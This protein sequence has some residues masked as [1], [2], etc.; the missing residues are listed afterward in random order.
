MQKTG[1]TR[2]MCCHDHQ[3]IKGKKKG[4]ESTLVKKNQKEATTRRLSRRQRE[5][6]EVDSF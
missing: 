3:A 4:R 1:A 5:E 2:D 6:A